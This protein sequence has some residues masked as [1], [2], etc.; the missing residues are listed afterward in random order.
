V[1]YSLPLEHLLRKSYLQTELDETGVMHSKMVCCFPMNFSN[2]RPNGL[3][4]LN[5]ERS[6]N[7]HSTIG[8][9]RNLGHQ[10]ICYYDFERDLINATNP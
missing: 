10:T 7:W 6:A 3:G 1:V 5:S 4:Q 9:R 8:R 2:T